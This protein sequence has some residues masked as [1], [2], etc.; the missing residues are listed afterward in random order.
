MRRRKVGKAYVYFTI[1][2]ALMVLP[3]KGEL[4][5][6]GPADITVIDPDAAWTITPQSLHGKSKNTPFLGRKVRG[7]AAWTIV[8][9][10]VRARDGIPGA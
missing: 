1:L 9:G 3:M 2:I 6:G 10:A 8:G 7:R 5:E 4:Q